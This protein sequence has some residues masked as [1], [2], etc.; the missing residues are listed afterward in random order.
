MYSK[1]FSFFLSL[2]S[3][4]LRIAVFFLISGDFFPFK[5]LA[6]K[7]QAENT[8]ASID[9]WLQAPEVLDLRQPDPALSLLFPMIHLRTTVLKRIIRMTKCW[10]VFP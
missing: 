4:Y 1:V 2:N 9:P 3:H 10:W 7:M 5:F 8:A 6:D